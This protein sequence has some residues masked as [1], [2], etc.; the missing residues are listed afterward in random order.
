MRLEPDGFFHLTYCTNIHPAEGWLAVFENIRRIAPVLKA[1][2]SPSRPFG[3]GLRL[4]AEEARE[5]LEGDRVAG[6]RSFLDREGLYVAII[7]G[8]PYGAFHGAPVK[9]NVYAPDWRDEARVQYTLNLIEILRRLVPDDVDGGV[10][11]APLSY[12]PWMSG[13][14]EQDWATITT[15]IA[16]VA[17]T[18]VRIRR[19][20]GQ[21]LH[22]DIEPEPDCLLEN[23][24]ETIEFFERWL[25]L[26]GADWLSARLGIT[27]AAARDAVREHIRVCFDCCHF[28]VEFED[29][30]VA[31]SRFEA[32]GIR[33]G[34]VQL[35]SALKVARPANAA[36]SAKA[37]AH[38]RA[39][40]RVHL[41]AS[42]GREEG[43]GPVPFFRPRCR[44]EKCV[45]SRDGCRMA[46]SFSCAALHQPL[47]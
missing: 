16:R 19:E 27:M 38:L 47:R 12:K 20:S 40:C 24:T 25:F 6:F 35:S 26:H 9:T 43:R 46:D 28:A 33:I 30:D 39:V 36:A 15:N 45:S 29:P 3:L 5:L 10:S 8:F 13:A 2:L 1:R 44:P 23:T 34:R 4:S 31:L 7:N 42:G 21:M 22:L 32:A 17:E 18:L 41:P 11:T 14:R 37:A